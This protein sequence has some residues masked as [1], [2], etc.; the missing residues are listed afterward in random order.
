MALG[1]ILG[2]VPDGLNTTGGSDMKRTGI[3]GDVHGRLDAL[4]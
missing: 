3:V 2:H 4:K 1:C